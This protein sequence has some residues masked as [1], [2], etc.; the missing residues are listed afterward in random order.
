MQVRETLPQQL[1][2]LMHNDRFTYSVYPAP[3]PLCVLVCTPGP[4]EVGGLSVVC[5]FGAGD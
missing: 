4:T 5:D 2:S 3:I 1:N